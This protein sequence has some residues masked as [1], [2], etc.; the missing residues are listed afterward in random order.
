MSLIADKIA[1]QGH[2]PTLGLLALTLTMVSKMTNVLLAM[3]H[4]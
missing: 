3:C 2:I 4:V 1:Q